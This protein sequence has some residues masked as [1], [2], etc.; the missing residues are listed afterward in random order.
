MAQEYGPAQPIYDAAKGIYK[1]VSGLIGDTSKPAATKVIDE[2]Y[3]KD[4]VEKANE[5]F[6]KDAEASSVRKVSTSS[7]TPPAK[8]QARQVSTSRKYINTKR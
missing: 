1:K 4:M 8:S 2:N 7:K 6:R 3:R 5:S